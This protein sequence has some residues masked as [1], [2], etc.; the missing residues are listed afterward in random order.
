MGWKQVPEFDSSSSFLDDNPF[1]GTRS[2]PTSKVSVKVLVDEW[3]CQKM[4]KWN[5][6]VQ[7]G[8]SSSTSETASLSR[9]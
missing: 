3:L 1:A 6:T 5:M 9:D 2:Q 7:E 4:E 8:Y